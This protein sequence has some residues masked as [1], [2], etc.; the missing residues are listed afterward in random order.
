[1]DLYTLLPGRVDNMNDKEPSTEAEA[2]LTRRTIL[3]FIAG[4]PLVA[5]FGFVASPLF[6]YLKPTMRPG[7]FF[8]AAD[9]PKAQQS[10][11]FSR[12]DFPEPW[13]CLPFMLPMSF[14]IFSPERHQIRQEPG[15]IVCTAKNEIV[16]FSRICTHCRHR[17]PINFMPNTLGISYLPQSKTPVL[18]CPC[19]CCLS[20]FDLSDGGSLLPFSTHI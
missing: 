9:L 4:A 16:A 14:K 3:K 5:T 18:V 15:F 20:T 17:Q 7:N 2:L 8:Q 1:M 13:T 11:R 6:R 10:V 12:R 19:D